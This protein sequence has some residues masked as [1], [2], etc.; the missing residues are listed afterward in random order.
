MT[1]STPTS[2]PTW[3]LSPHTPSSASILDDVIERLQ[4][5]QLP[6]LPELSFLVSAARLLLLSTPNLVCL[7]S[8]VTVVGDIHGQFN[9]LLELLLLCGPPPLSSYLFLGDYVDRGPM[10][11]S[12]ISLLLAMLVRH[13][14]RVTLLRGNHESRVISRS[15]G[16]YDECMQLYDSA[17]GWQ[18]LCSVFDCLPLAATVDGTVLCLHGGLCPSLHSLSELQAIDRFCEVGV[19]GG[20]MCDLMWSDPEPE[21]AGFMRSTRGAGWTFGQD[22]TERFLHVNGLD[23]IVRAHQLCQEGYSIL[24]DNCGPSPTTEAHGGFSSPHQPRPLTLLMCRCCCVCRAV[25]VWSAPNYCGRMGNRAS[26]LQMDEQG[27]QSRDRRSRCCRQLPVAAH[28]R[29][30]ALLCCLTGRVF[31][32]FTEGPARFTAQRKDAALAASA[33]APRSAAKQRQLLSTALSSTVTPRADWEEKQ[34]AGAADSKETEELKVSAGKAQSAAT[35]HA[36]EV[37]RDSAGDG[38]G[39]QARPKAVK[40]LKR[41][42]NKKPSIAALKKGGF[43]YR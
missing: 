27:G 43:A 20:L 26:V 30:S 12:T 38:G 1:N 9:D 2:S 7:S 31:H 37:S 10:S 41:N 21:Q 8:P 40:G 25:T 42:V 15:Y 39:W 23:C 5:G 33:S 14:S 24:W 16:L 34:I 13:P 35:A 11:V 29:A 17:A 28:M 36:E 19:D 4:A 6:S 3:S 18:L 22:V 32:I